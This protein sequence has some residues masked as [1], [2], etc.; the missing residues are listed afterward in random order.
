MEAVTLRL[1][2]RY[3]NVEVQVTGFWKKADK[4]PDTHGLCG[5]YDL[6]WWNDHTRADGEGC[7]CRP[8]LVC[9]RCC[10]V[11]IPLLPAGTDHGALRR[12]TKCQAPVRSSRMALLHLRLSE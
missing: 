12:P 3:I 10:V 6:N 5:N 8:R 9:E 11:Q 4:K 1:R 7:F 2:C